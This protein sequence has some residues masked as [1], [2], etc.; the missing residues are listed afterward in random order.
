[1]GLQLEEHLLHLVQLIRV[2]AVHRIPKVPERTS[3]DVNIEIKHRCLAG[4]LLG[5]LPE[6]MPGGGTFRNEIFPIPEAGL[7]IIGGNPVRKLA[8]KYRRNIF[9]VGYRAPV[10]C[11][12]VPRQLQLPCDGRPAQCQIELATVASDLGDVLSVANQTG[13]RIPDG[14]LRVEAVELRELVRPIPPGITEKDQRSRQLR[15]RRWLR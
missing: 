6:I 1:M 4:I 11:V 13:G 15:S 10:E 5:Q 3:L 9:E 2:R 12:K 7:P 14:Q 8:L